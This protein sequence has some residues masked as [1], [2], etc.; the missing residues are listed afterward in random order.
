VGCTRYNENGSCTG[1]GFR[2][3]LSAGICLR[4]S[5]S[6]KSWNLITG[7][8]NTCYDGNTILGN[9]CVPITPQTSTSF[10][11]TSTVSTV[12]VTPTL[13]V[14]PAVPVAPV[15]TATVVS[16]Q[17]NQ[18]TITTTT[19]Q[20]NRIQIAGCTTYNDNGS[21]ALCG[22]RFYLSG[23][24]CLKVSDTCKSWNLNTGACNSCYDNFV[25]A[26][27][28]CVPSLVQVPPISLPSS[29]TA[30]SGTTTNSQAQTTYSTSTSTTALPATATTNNVQINVLP[31]V[32]PTITVPIVPSSQT[33]QSITSQTTTGQSANGQ[34]ATG[35]SSQSTTNLRTQ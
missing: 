16:P 21:C 24:I 34:S 20:T 4:V 32:Q 27:A 9:E 2:F 23:G 15:A 26:G 7:A 28:N 19:V 14:A 35:Q 1:C 31:A 33:T 25:I 10:T 8:C 22:F 3:Y 13:P 18:G 11:T 6:C 30:T 5:D 12:Q 17:N 29:S